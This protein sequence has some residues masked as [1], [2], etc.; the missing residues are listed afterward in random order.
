M[1]GDA[2]EF[3]DQSVREEINGFTRVFSVPGSAGCPDVAMKP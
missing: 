1:M 3:G 2:R